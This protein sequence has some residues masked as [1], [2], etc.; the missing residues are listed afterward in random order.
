MGTVY[1]GVQEGT[2]KEVAVKVLSPSLLPDDSFRDR[3]ESE[4]KSL[5]KLRHSRIVELYGFGEQDGQLFYAMEL[6]RGSSLQE[7]LAAGRRFDW[8]EVIRIGMDV[9]GAL[10]HAHDHGVIHRDI[11]PA[12][13]ILD[14]DNQIRLTDFG[15]A[16][17]FGSTSQTIDGGVL[18]TADFM[19]PE[20][21][22]GQMVT[23]RSD[24][25]SLG[26][27]LYTLLA[28]RPPFQ[29]KSLP[30]V[31]H[32][33]RFEPPLPVRRFAPETP[34][35]LEELLDQLLA[36]DPRQRA[37][38]ALA[39]SKRLMAIEHALSLGPATN[40]VPK[41]A[42]VDAEDQQQ[43]ADA[44]FASMETAAALP[45]SFERESTHH[46]SISI[47]ESE[48]VSEEAGEIRPQSNRYTTVDEDYRRR[49]GAGETTVETPLEFWSK[50]LG[51][52]GLLA[53]GAALIW[54]LT[55]PPSADQLFANIQT[56][57]ESGTDDELIA[58]EDDMRKFLLYFPEEPRREQVT[59]WLADVKLARLNR[60]LELISRSPITPR[61]V[62]PI[63]LL[64][65]K[66]IR[67]EITDE[68]SAAKQLQAIL[69]FFPPGESLGDEDRRCID[70]ARRRLIELKR[71][72]TG[73]DEQQ[74]DFVVERLKIATEVAKDD[75]DTA[76]RIRQ[77]IV[78]LYQKDLWAQE[79]VKEARH[80]LD[81]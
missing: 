74:R 70:L 7:E 25:Y 63:E 57:A 24:V 14:Q 37:P 55:R 33:V 56:A 44:E 31:I 8:R 36:K 5:E 47:V 49:L 32:K 68:A 62:R 28:G 12:N 10:K 4:I 79:Y 23:P 21:A 17:L 65:L 39:L 69:A 35:E 30:E 66:A 81:E 48:P 34:E 9:C 59:D 29:G 40:P 6:V 46:A 1:R 75:P 43:A 61:N 41:P 11:K 77:G 19:A 52:I 67:T 60:R 76:R 20:Q 71:A 64:L 80:L 13:L 3:F 50:W 27:V 58:N 42:A 72:A 16:K 73:I 78:D 38:T 54:F 53:G 18:G 15:I 22:E 45:S 2:G 51:L 26:A